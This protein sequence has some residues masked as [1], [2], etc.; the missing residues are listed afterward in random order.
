MNTHTTKHQI[1]NGPDGVPQYVVIPYEEYMKIAED[2]EGRPDEEV[3]IPE[4]VA[5]RVIVQNKSYVRAWREYKGM[6]QL[7]VAERMGVSRAAFAQMEASS[8]NLRVSTYKKIAEAL[9]VEWEQL[10]A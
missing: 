2:V 3:L 8:A 6:T 7:D 1:I 5:D 9:G 4:E 10:R